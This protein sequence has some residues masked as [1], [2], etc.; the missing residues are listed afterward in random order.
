MKKIML[1][2]FVLLLHGVNGYAANG[3]LVVNG[4]ISVGTAITFADGSK[5]YS[6]A[7][8]VLNG[9]MRYATPGSY[10]FTVPAG[11]GKILFEAWGAGGGGGGYTG[12]S[13]A[14]Y[15][16]G[17]G[18]GGQYRGSFA[19]TPGQTY[20]V[21]VGAGGAGSLHSNGGNGGD[22]SFGGTLAVAHGGGGGGVAVGTVVGT[23]G[24]GGTGGGWDPMDGGTAIS[25]SLYGGGGTSTSGSLFGGT[26]TTPLNNNGGS[27]GYYSQYGNIYVSG[28]NGGPGHAN[29]YW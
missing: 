16:G 20:T 6:A 21:I 8:G 4:N 10:T 29:I 23:P 25:G 3:D 1:L 26:S 27:V 9:M 11:V 13:Y 12:T 14:V 17:G 28:A 7:S 15:G 19:V 2:L 22:T 24:V 5:Q 18:G